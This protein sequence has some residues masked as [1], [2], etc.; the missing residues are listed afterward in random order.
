MD[1]PAE[2]GLSENGNGIFLPV[3]NVEMSLIGFNSRHL[4]EASDLLGDS[5]GDKEEVAVLVVLENASGSKIEA[6]N[7]TVA[8]DVDI[9]DSRREELILRSIVHGSIIAECHVII[10]EDIISGGVELLHGI[11]GLRRGG[12]AGEDEI[13]VR[14]EVGDTGGNVSRAP[15]AL[16]IGGKEVGEIA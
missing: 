3:R 14:V 1:S 6:I 16:L 8:G 15:A 11:G 9:A 12:G 5:A 7:V 4:R 10:G 13:L 2:I